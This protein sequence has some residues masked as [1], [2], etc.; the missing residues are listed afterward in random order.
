MSL[1]N[2]LGTEAEYCMWSSFSFGMVGF[3]YAQE[4]LNSNE[5]Q[6]DSTK[7]PSPNVKGLTG[8]PGSHARK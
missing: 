6:I 4:S 7:L 1:D 2:L 3:A 8:S 5:I